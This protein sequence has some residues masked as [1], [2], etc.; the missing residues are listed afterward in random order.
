MDDARK[1]ENFVKRL[2]AAVRTHG[3]YSAS[4]PISRRALDMLAAAVDETLLRAPQV[5]VGFLGD[6]VLVGH[7]RLR[8]SVFAQALVRRFRELRVEKFT[9]ARGLP[10]DQLGTLV[11]LV[12]DQDER[13]LAD[14]LVAAGITGVS[15]GAILPTNADTTVE[16]GV[17]AARQLY[18]AAVENAEAV[19]NAAKENREA[20]PAAARS[21][22]D[23]L[24]DAMADTPASV[25]A[26]TALK[27]H[28][29][30]T[31]THMV[32]VAI[33][34]M[35][36]ARALGMNDQLVREFGLAGFLHDVG[37]T[38]VP[39]E[40]LN[41]PG[42]LNDEERPIMQRHV[43]DGAQILRKTPGLPALAPIVAFEHHLRQDLSGYPTNIGARKLN[44]CTMIV[45]IADVFDALRSNRAYREGLPEQRVRHML[46]QQAGR[47]FEPTLLRRFVTL[48]GIFPV[49]TFVALTTGE[50]GVVTAEH[51]SDPFRPIVSVV[52]DRSGRR[53]EAPVSIDTSVRDD[54]GSFVC[55]VGEAVDGDEFGIDPLTVLG[56]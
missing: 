39:V 9:L 38:R 22:I 18:G 25:M 21:I 12:A 31:F 40:I 13:P 55:G 35:A 5:T 56:T 2:A 50:V 14:R 3:I 26:L 6:D 23:S 51:P 43:V 46:D 44:L 48:M 15:V 36:Q 4:H 10:P 45:S 8:G 32:N 42:Q 11:R 20:D 27:S 47:A 30:Y 28:D 1:A 53:P 7:T 49:G 24:A 37:K 19:W 16:M 52:V 54:A 29:A 34:T 17:K 41:K 33:L